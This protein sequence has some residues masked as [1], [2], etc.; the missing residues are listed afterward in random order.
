MD[1]PSFL[2]EHWQLGWDTDLAIVQRASPNGVSA[3]I[4]VDP[5]G[6]PR[7][8]WTGGAKQTSRFLLGRL[9]FFVPLLR[10]AKSRLMTKA[11]TWDQAASRAF[12]A[13]LLA[14]A[15]GLRNEI[16]GV[17]NISQDQL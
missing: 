11:Y 5:S 3:M 17:T 2:N 8:A 1:L 16:N 12:A 13:E 14:P 6:M 4:S 9:L 10:K 7:I 15:D